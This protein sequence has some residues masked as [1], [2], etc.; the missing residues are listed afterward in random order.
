MNSSTTVDG[1]QT[2]GAGITWISAAAQVLLYLLF[3]GLSGAIDIGQFRA[4][5][6]DA[7]RQRALFAG[8]ACQFLVRSYVS[9]QGGYGLTAVE[10]SMT[11]PAGPGVRSR[12]RLGPA[13]AECC[14]AA[15]SYL[16]ARRQLQQSFLRNFQRRPSPI[17]RNDNRFYCL[18]DFHAASKC[19]ALHS[20]LVWKQPGL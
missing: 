15:H 7:S 2:S 4:T 9:G 1:A 13:Y 16:L 6:K 14:D 3:F 10:L 12:Q 11:G 20:A 19:C 17:N 5:F 8:V 18:R